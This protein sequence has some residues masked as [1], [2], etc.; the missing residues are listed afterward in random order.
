MFLVLTWTL[1]EQFRI[2]VTTPQHEKFPSG[3]FGAF[4][5]SPT[6]KNV[7]P[8]P[9]EF[10]LALTKEGVIVSPRVCLGLSKNNE[11]FQGWIFIT[12]FVLLR[13]VRSQCWN[14]A[15]FPIN[16]LTGC[17]FLFLTLF[18]PIQ[19]KVYYY[20]LRIFGWCVAKVAVLSRTFSVKVRMTDC[21]ANLIQLRKSLIRFG[22]FTTVH[23][24]FYSFAISWCEYE[25]FLC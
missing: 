19:D 24:N 15:E 8:F 14:Y 22:L 20:S 10:C 7:G 11:V 12:M 3:N 9:A 21:S 25:L 23:T 5:L 6:T 13:L 17:S 16:L 18:H 2:S 4:C 1:R